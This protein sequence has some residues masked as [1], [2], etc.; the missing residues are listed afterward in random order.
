MFSCVP[1]Q[2]DC[3][4]RDPRS[5]TGDNTCLHGSGVS[6]PSLLARFGL[7]SSDFSARAQYAAGVSRYRIGP[8]ARLRHPAKPNAACPPPWTAM[9]V[10]LRVRETAADRCRL[11]ARGWPQHP[12]VPLTLPGVRSI[13][14]TSPRRSIWLSSCIAGTE[15]NAR[16]RIPCEDATRRSKLRSST[17]G[18]AKQNAVAAIK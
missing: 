10:N 16:V 9:I 13:N 12:S 6:E 15:R 7:V 5:M 4:V 3:C 1:T 2:A 18:S 14:T 17:G 11:A 8:F